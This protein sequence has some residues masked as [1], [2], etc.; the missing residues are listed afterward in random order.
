MRANYRSLKSLKTYA[1]PYTG[2]KLGKHEFD[3]TIDKSFFDEFEHS[4]VQEGNLNCH[5][6]LDKQERMIILDFTIEGNIELTCDRCLDT[7]SYPLFTEEQQIFKF[8]EEEMNPD[9]EIIILHKND[10]EINVAGLIYEYISVAVPLIKL[11]EDGNKE[12][13]TEMLERLK[14][15]SGENDK[16]NNTGSDPRWDALKNIK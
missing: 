9:D 3:F 4:L 2:L 6:E 7:F 10:Q 16:E 11:C 12:C 15:F 13:N 5:L 14:S 8:S 1:I